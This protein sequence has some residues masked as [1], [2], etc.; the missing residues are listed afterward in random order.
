MTSSNI[1]LFIFR[2]DLRLSDNTSLKILLQTCSVVYPIFIFTPT[3]VDKNPFKSEH[4]IQFMIESL[5][6]LEIQIEEKSNAKLIC[7]YGENEE[8]ISELVKLL[9]ITHIG[10]NSD[11]TPYSKKRDDSITKLA[12]KLNIEIISEEDYTLH[13]FKSKILHNPN[14]NTIFKKFTPFHKSILNRNLKPS[15]IITIT[16]KDLNKLK[17][18]EETNNKIVLS[19]AYDKFINA[20]NKNLILYGGR[21][22]G[23]A[24]LALSKTHQTDYENSRNKL[25]VK[26]SQVSAYLKYGCLSIREVFKFWK[27]TLGKNNG[28]IRQLYWR[29]FYAY[30]LNEHPENLGK[31]MNPKYDNIKWKEDKESNQHFESWKDGNTGFPIVD[32]AMRQLNTTGYMHNRG[33]L[34]VASFLVKTLLI[35][36]RKGEKYFA[37]KLLDYDVASNN[38]NWQ[39]IAGS[40]VDSQPY[41][42]IFN[43][44]SQSVT[45]DPDC[46]YIKTFVPELN[47]LDSKTI[48]KW[49]ECYKKYNNIDYPKPIVNYHINKLMVLK[50]YEK[51]LK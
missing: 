28:L 13:N 8:I 16:K 6:D 39:W 51:A 26:T 3:Q 32:A 7:F 38:G 42:R 33:R 44:W 35:D 30:I 17:S 20:P 23:K 49:N 27:D 22:H 1:G 31:A 40:G 2:R 34:I 37:Q 4:S 11:F 47:E 29:E 9:S 45:H 12:S 36:W 14:T 5:C 41:F 10:Y 48:H 50:E 15:K 18:C 19:D 25:S 21:I 46:I 24:L 43:P